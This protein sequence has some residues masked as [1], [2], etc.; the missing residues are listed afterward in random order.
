GRWQYNP[1]KWP[2]PPQIALDCVS[3]PLPSDLAPRWPV[4][5]PRSSR[6]VPRE[7]RPRPRD[8]PNPACRSQRD[9]SLRRGPFA[10]AA[11]PFLTLPA[12][13]HPSRDI[14]ANAHPR[15]QVVWQ[16]TVQ[17]P[18]LVQRLISHRAWA[19]QGAWAAYFPLFSSFSMKCVSRFPAT[20]LGCARI[21][22]WRGMEVFI[23]SITNISRARFMRLMASAR[24]RPFT[25]SLATIES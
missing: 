21:L 15:S 4:S 6:P 9:L 18:E 3:K 23:P 12:R 2:L 13:T 7:L 1:P 8:T 22:R 5:A 14:A 17:A 25:M 10:L 16:S 20:K 19:S 24:S 11:W